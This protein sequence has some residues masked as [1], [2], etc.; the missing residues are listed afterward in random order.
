MKL[1]PLTSDEER[2]LRRV[3]EDWETR[4]PLQKAIAVAVLR[5]FNT[6]ETVASHLQIT[7]A[8]VRSTL[9]S[10]WGLLLDYTTQKIWIK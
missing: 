3:I 6:P 8:E 1:S 2:A 4:S 10:I 9:P 5:G 7:V